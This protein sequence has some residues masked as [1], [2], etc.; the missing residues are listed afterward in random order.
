MR[1]FMHVVITAFLAMPAFAGSYERFL[2]PVHTVGAPILGAH[3]VRWSTALYVLND[4]DHDIIIGPCAPGFPENPASPCLPSFISWPAATVIQNPQAGWTE[5]GRR[6]RLIW[7]QREDAPHLSFSLTLLRN[8]A[9]VARL[10]VPRSDEFSTRIHLIGVPVRSDTRLRIYG[11]DNTSAAVQIRVFAMPDASGS[12]A[13][14]PLA[15]AMVTLDPSPYVDPSNLAYAPSYA[16]LLIPTLAATADAVWL[17]ITSLDDAR[18]W[19]FAT[20]S[21][22]AAVD[23]IQPR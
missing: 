16:E 7:A 20:A 8:G 21:R 14:H 17:E 13:A 3:G 10:S 19:A 6:G 12:A 5:A 15:E 11:L 2:L 9:A 1:V 22:D 23:V 18:L 4:A